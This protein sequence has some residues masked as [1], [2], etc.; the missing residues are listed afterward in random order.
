[1]NKL[2]FFTSEVSSEEVTEVSSEELYNYLQNECTSLGVAFEENPE[3]EEVKEFLENLCKNDLFAVSLKTST[4]VNVY[5]PTRRKDDYDIRH[6]P[7]DESATPIS[8]YETVKD[9]VLQIEDLPSFIEKL[10]ELSRVTASRTSPLSSHSDVER[11]SALASI[12]Y[13]ATLMDFA[14][15]L[16]HIEMYIQLFSAYAIEE[17]R[18]IVNESHNVADISA[19][20]YAAVLK[21]ERSYE[22]PY[23][24][25]PKIAFEHNGKKV[26]QDLCKVR[27]GFYIAQGETNAILFALQN[28]E[29]IRK[30][31]QETQ[32]AIDHYKIYLED[33]GN[34]YKKVYYENKNRFTE[35]FGE[36]PGEVFDIG[37]PV[38]FYITF[39][40]LLLT[41]MQSRY[42]EVRYLA[43]A[44]RYLK[45][46]FPDEEEVLDETDMPIPSI[47]ALINKLAWN[48]DDNLSLYREN[49][50]AIE[51]YNAQ[52][53]KYKQL[54]RKLGTSAPPNHAAGLVYALS[55]M[56]KLGVKEVKIP[57]Y[58]PLRVTDHEHR[59]G[60]ARG[61]E[62]DNRRL[63]NLLEA[64]SYATAKVSGI[65]VWQ[66]PGTSEDG[67]SYMTLRL[68]DMSSDK[69]ILQDLI[70]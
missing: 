70:S 63:H 12:W 48:S 61:H 5:Y 37:D 23:S 11:E 14:E 19:Q 13:N 26:E 18:G 49:V 66:D 67:V 57:L 51:E 40:N 17:A 65:E 52:E 25:V 69:R 30:N 44:V 21:E 64:I 55:V 62:V 45:G 24:I 8:E 36:F 47:G 27:A 42:S 60:E 28:S 53:K 10:K 31:K 34:F 35:V 46:D 50:A 29:N 4:G 1:M 58:L 43:Q 15:P 56:Y 7:Q 22:T 59:L 54:A 39:T 33:E 20:V 2:E 6:T 38:D 16:N 41:N 68:S 3:D 9:P 32:N